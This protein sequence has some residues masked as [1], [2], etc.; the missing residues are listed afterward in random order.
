MLSLNTVPAEPVCKC[1]APPDPDRVHHRL[2]RKE[3]L[4]LREY[5]AALAS[6][7]AKRGFKMVEYTL[8][9]D[10]R[11]GAPLPGESCTETVTVVL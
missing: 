1:L 6:V 9:D 8:E 5:S 4:A 10:L 11:R 7:Y 3:K 2:Y